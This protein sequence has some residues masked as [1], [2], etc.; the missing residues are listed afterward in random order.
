L[1]RFKI[2]KAPTNVHS[3]SPCQLSSLESLQVVS[4]IRSCAPQVHGNHAWAGCRSVVECLPS[5]CEVLG[6]M[7]STEKNAHTHTHT[8]THKCS[9]MLV[10]FPCRS[11]HA[12]PSNNVCMDHPISL[13]RALS[14]LCNVLW[15]FITWKIWNYLNSTL[16]MDCIERS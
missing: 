16:L 7:L 4:V 14:Y 6:L 5:R 3:K 2:W 13:C 10:L 11:H 12:F 15:H 8:H 9:Y 1:S